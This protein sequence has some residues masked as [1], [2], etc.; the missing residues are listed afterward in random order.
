[1]QYA[2]H[3][4]DDSTKKKSNTPLSAHSSTILW[5]AFVEFYPN[6]VSY[7]L[8]L[9]STFSRDRVRFTTARHLSIGLF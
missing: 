6:N 7:A 3:K 2:P 9:H 1:M 4:A 8:V 5:C